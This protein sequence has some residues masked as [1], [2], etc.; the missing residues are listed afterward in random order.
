M[1]RIVYEGRPIAA[2]IHDP[3][4]RTEPEL[5]QDGQPDAHDHGGA[6]KSMDAALQ[7]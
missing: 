2:V 4:L 5:L 6:L 7:E 3:A 1:T